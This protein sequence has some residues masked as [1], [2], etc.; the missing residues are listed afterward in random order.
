M[1]A[2]I[3]WILLED[4]GEHIQLLYVYHMNIVNQGE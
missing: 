2:I 4:E 1:L 3:S